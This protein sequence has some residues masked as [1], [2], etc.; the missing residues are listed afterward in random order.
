MFC[1]RLFL[2]T[3]SAVDMMNVHSASA[4]RRRRER[5]LR[6]FLRHERLSVALALSEKKHHT[7]PSSEDGQGRGG[8]GGEGERGG[9]GSRCTTPLSSGCTH[10]PA[11]ALP[12]VRGGGAER[13]MATLSG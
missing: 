1:A 12:A 11:G 2:E 5:R 9:G 7:S 8:K 6:Q 4:A 13:F 10:P 3:A